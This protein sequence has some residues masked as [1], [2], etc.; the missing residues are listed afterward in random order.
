MKTEVARVWRFVN[1]HPLTKESV[2]PA[3]WRFLFW[4][5]HS[6]LFPEIEWNWIEGSKLV[7]RKGMTGATGN[8]YAGLHEFAD[9]AFLL[10]FLRP[11]ELFVDVGANIGSY[12]VLASSVVGTRV[13]AIEPDPITMGHLKRNLAVNQ[14]N[15]LVQTEEVAIGASLGTVQFT[16]GQDTTN[17]VSSDP[18]VAT[19]SVKLTTLDLLLA[20]EKP[21]FIKL[22]VEGYETEA[23]A[24]ARQT[25]EM[26][27]LAAIATECDDRAIIELLV[28]HGFQRVWYDPF[29][30]KLHLEP[31]VVQSNALFVRDFDACQARLISAKAIH[32]LDRAI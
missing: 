11:N 15:H 20:Q 1:G 21:V 28:A 2:I 31:I 17:Q 7:V 29:Q 19:R 24:G 12:T 4:Q 25:L 10:H 30:R 14:V 23:L 27:S 8:I 9:M 22:D 18:N 13:L 32:V 6:R 26:A 5:I 3:L 16:I